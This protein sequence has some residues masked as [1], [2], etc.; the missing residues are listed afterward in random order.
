ML[1]FNKTSKLVRSQTIGRGQEFD[2]MSTILENIIEHVEDMKNSQ[3][4]HS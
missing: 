4:V 3:M 1:E 2:V